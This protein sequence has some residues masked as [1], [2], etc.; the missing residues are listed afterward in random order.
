MTSALALPGAELGEGF[1]VKKAKIRGVESIGMLCS[2]REMGISDDHSGIVDLT[3][4]APVGSPIAD[5]LNLETQVL[6]ISITPN[7]GDAL[8]ILGV[9]RDVAAIY[10]LELT[11]PTIS[12]EEHQPPITDD[13]EIT[14]SFPEGCP[15]YAARLVRGVSAAPSP[16]WMADRL[17]ACDVRPISAV[18]DVTNY[19]LMERGQPLHAFDYAQLAKK[20]IDVRAAEEGERFTTLD[21]QERKLAAGMTL[22][23]DGEKPVALA[24]IMGGLNSEITDA[25]EAVLIESANFDPLTT[26]RTGKALGLSTEAGYRFERGVDRDGCAIAADRARPAHRP[27]GR[28]AG[29]SRAHRCA[30]HPLRSSPDCAFGEKDRRLHRT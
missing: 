6:E 14:I 21:G 10:G 16:I 3:T 4:D 11:E 7:R 12:I 24:G 15:R 2:E 8:S 28:G 18:V 1:V 23:C 19:V 22:I 17:S 26:R 30:P 27:S 25:T 5:A 13:V 29:G 9:A 20:R